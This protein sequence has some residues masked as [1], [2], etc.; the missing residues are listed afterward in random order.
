ML[1]VYFI[2]IPDNVKLLK[3]NLI[4]TEPLP[5]SFHK[6]IIMQH[7]KTIFLPFNEGN[8]GTRPD[9]IYFYCT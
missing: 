4:T 8:E 2:Y 1:V 6:C 5:Y 9:K 3:K 7:C